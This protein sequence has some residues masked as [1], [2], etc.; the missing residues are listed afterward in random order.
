MILPIL[1]INIGSESAQNLTSI[2]QYC[3]NV[4]TLRS[5]VLYWR[6]FMM[7]ERNRVELKMLVCRFRGCE[8]S[9]IISHRMPK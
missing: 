6:T 4:V 9:E 8:E 7:A 2:D 5:W 1:G 3:L